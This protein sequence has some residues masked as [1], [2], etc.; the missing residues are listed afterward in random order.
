MGESHVVSALVKRRA[1]LAGE[2]EA[3][4]GRLK[5]LRASLEHLDA[6]LLMF[7]PDAEPTAIAPKAWRPKVDWAGRGEMVRKTLAVLRAS[8]EPLTAREIALRIM[9]ADAAD[10]DSLP[11]VKAMTKR[12]N[13]ALRR[14][15]E[16]GLVAG[17]PGPG[18]AVLWHLAARC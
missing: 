3:V 1:E 12:T 9:H 2:I 10:T 11:A 14:Q 8:G 15:R 17:E 18:M 4:A 5:A 13:E 16:R 6:T 7:E